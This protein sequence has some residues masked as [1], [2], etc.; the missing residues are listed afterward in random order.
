MARVFAQDVI[1]ISE[2]QGIDS[3]FETILLA[4]GRA[5]KLKKLS[6]DKKVLPAED[7]ESGSL[8]VSALREIESGHLDLGQEK[9]DF[10]QS[11][12]KVKLPSEEDSEEQQN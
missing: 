3:T 10:I 6:Q 11:L 12:C 5:K 4:S 7:Y 1:K 2:S 9:D 8:A